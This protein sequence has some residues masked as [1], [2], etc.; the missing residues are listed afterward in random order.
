LTLVD[1]T[2]EARLVPVF[3]ALIARR[4]A[5]VAIYIVLLAA[6]AMLA[7]DI[8]RDN[9]IENTV[10][11][12]D[13]EVAVSHEFS[14][15]FPEGETVYLMLE[16]GDPFSVGPLTELDRLESELA[17]IPGVTPYS[18]ATIWRRSRPGAGPPAAHLETFRTLFE[19]TGLDEVVHVAGALD[20]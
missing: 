8:P 2:L 15:I 11:A 20:L 18:I 4:R 10:V 16:T 13:P 19:G 17:V 6:A 3:D 14:A 7:F 5:V 9:S 1:R 12:S